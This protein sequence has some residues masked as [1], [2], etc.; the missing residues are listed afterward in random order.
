M[1]TQLNTIADLYRHSPQARAVPKAV[2]AL[3]SNLPGARGI[4]GSA[5]G[6]NVR[7]VL[8]SLQLL[9][10]APLLASDIIITDPVDCPPGSPMFAN[11]VVVICPHTS[12]SP[13]GLLAELQ[14]IEARFGRQRKGVRNEARV[15]D[16]DIISFGEHL[17]DSTA[18]TLPHPRA[19]QRLFVLEPLCQVWPDFCF[20]GDSRSVQELVRILRQ[21]A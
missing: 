12:L 21:G 15:V 10:T 16:L 2:I 14:G 19:R 9:S 11:A 8:P 4:M 6:D 13:Q 20:P 5:P 1:S 17:I 3:G 7:A 18:L